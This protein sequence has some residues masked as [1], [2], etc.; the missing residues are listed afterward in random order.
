M[1]DKDKIT[2]R[3]PPNLIKLIN[4]FLETSATYL[5]LSEFAR[6]A[7]REKIQRDAPWLFEE[8]VRDT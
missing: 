1:E 5:N 3:T 6:T 4:R 7:L 2:I 8:G